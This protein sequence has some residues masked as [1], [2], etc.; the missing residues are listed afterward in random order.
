M[1]K[2]VGMEKPVTETKPSTHFDRNQNQDESIP[3][4]TKFFTTNN[5]K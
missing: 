5:T 4:C 2:Q 1:L 3:K